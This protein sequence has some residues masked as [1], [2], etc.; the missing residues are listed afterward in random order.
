MGYMERC[1]KR[2]LMDMTKEEPSPF[3]WGCG[4]CGLGYRQDLLLHEGRGKEQ[5]KC[6]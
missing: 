6:R 2:V 3:S 5:G 4:A 1:W